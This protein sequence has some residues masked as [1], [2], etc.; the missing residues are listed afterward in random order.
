[1]E[2]VPIQIP[3]RPPFL[4]GGWKD[5]LSVN[6]S[7]ERSRRSL[8]ESPSGQGLFGPRCPQKPLKSSQGCSP[9]LENS[10]VFLQ[11]AICL[12]QWC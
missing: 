12:P 8:G 2:T 9:Y 10:S 7:T 4:K 6:R 3:P 1:M 5:Y 11:D